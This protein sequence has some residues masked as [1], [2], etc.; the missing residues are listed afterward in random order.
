MYF[1]E[2][3]I[4]YRYFQALGSLFW[5]V[6]YVLPDYSRTQF[7]PDPKHRLGAAI[8]HLKLYRIFLYTFFVVVLPLQVFLGGLPSSITETDL[9]AFFGRYGEVVEVVIMYDQGGLEKNQGFLGFLGF[10][11]VF[12]T[13]KRE[14]L[15]FFSFKNTFRCIQT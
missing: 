7:E 8:N 5:G 11:W 15:G 2:A 6:N 9:R 4:K 10:F 3:F 12:F 13:Q 14:F 1:S